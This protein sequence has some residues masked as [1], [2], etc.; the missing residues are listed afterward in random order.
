MR[1]GSTSYVTD[2][3]EYNADSD[4][5]RSPPGSETPSLR[6]LLDEERCP[7]SDVIMNSAG[8]GGHTNENKEVAPAIRQ[9]LRTKLA[10]LM[11]QAAI[12]ESST[13]FLEKLIGD[14]NNKVDMLAAQL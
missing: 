2:S 7:A 8:T 5:D 4:D 1:K 11:V 13:R 10:G 9:E 14:L 3:E 12:V 6:E